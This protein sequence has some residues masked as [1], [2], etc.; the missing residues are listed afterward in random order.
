MH[1]SRKTRAAKPIKI[2]SVWSRR[3]NLDTS[4]RALATLPPTHRSNQTYEQWSLVGRAVTEF[5]SV[6]KRN[7]P[8]EAH[9]P[10]RVPCSLWVILIVLEVWSAILPVSAARSSSAPIMASTAPEFQILHKK[11]KRDDDNTKRVGAVPAFS[12]SPR[13]P[14][15]TA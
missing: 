4:P 14:C 11:A 12:P 1:V 13:S 9:L 5:Q 8:R 3:R 7:P 6:I 2:L 10:D 15:Q